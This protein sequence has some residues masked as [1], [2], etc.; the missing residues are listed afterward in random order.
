ML[1]NLSEM[2]IKVF[3]ISKKLFWDQPVIIKK[4]EEVSK[5]TTPT[6]VENG[7]INGTSQSFSALYY[8]FM[9]ILKQEEIESI[10]AIVERYGKQIKELITPLIVSELE[11]NTGDNKKELIDQLLKFEVAET[12]SSLLYHRLREAISLNQFKEKEGIP[13]VEIKNGNLTHIAE[14]HTHN[15]DSIIL[16]NAE[17]EQWETLMT[18]AITSMD[19]L[20]AD[21]FDV[22]SILWM[23]S[24]NSES[25][26]LSFSHE[27]VLKMRQIQKKKNAAGYESFRKK[28][29]DEVMRRLAALASIWIKV[30]EDDDVQFIEK[31]NS[32]DKEYKQAR[33]KRLFQVDNVTVAH[34]RSTNEM[35]GIVECD[36]RPGEL[37][38]S[39]LFGAKRS[40][41]FLSLKAL[42]Y[43]PIKHKYHK[44]LT[45]YLSWQWR[46][47][48]RKADFERPY[49]IGGSKG[50]LLSVM[51]MEAIYDRPM[52]TRESFENVLDT[53]QDDGVINTWYYAEID[54]D[55]IGKGNKGWLENYWMTLTVVILPPEEMLMLENK[56]TQQNPFLNIDMKLV[57]EMVQKS[58][59]QV[60]DLSDI[61]AE[62]VQLS[63]DLLFDKRD[64]IPK[65][66]EETVLSPK[67]VQET[68]K[69]RG[70]TLSR[71][72]K[73]IGIAHTTLSRYEKG[74]ILKPNKKNDEKIKAWID[75]L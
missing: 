71:A 15:E 64:A 30:D 44:R 11:G 18:Q 7:I 54:E 49:K 52:R 70:L 57:T 35:I 28:D 19:D 39:Y 9:T 2:K 63:L 73:E 13:R 53:L 50:G 58:N 56:N 38:S 17:V 21:T 65:K 69:K 33:L 47:R 75:A 29:R 8:L 59:E 10:N 55:K 23:K 41:G 5:V 42:Q 1:L 61:H 34:D 20:T 14:I 31:R 40:T 12:G 25:D 43:N 16:T 22:I 24:A 27:D 45:R 4:W 37:L 26:V 60:E 6:E 67:L 46:I 74:V 72:A 62:P 48:Q 32:L 66:D 68:R 3:N 51:G 36:I